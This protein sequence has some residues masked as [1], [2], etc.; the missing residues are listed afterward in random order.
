MFVRWII[1][2]HSGNDN[3]NQ[4]EQCSSRVCVASAG[5]YESFEDVQKFG[6]PSANNFQSCLCALK[7]CSYRLCGTAYV[8]YSSHSNLYYVIR[9][10]KVSDK[11]SANVTR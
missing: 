11:R 10:C 3:D 6:V 5:Q 9:A 1:P 4:F 2:G 8:L 7:T